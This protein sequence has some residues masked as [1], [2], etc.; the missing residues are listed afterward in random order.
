MKKIF[1]LLL[2][3]AV[4]ASVS[5][6]SFAAST[7]IDGEGSPNPATGLGNG[8]YSITVNADYIGGSGG[9]VVSVDVQWDAMTFTYQEVTL[10]TWNPGSHSYIGTVDGGWSDNKPSITVTNHSNV[11]VTAD[12]SFATGYSS[13]II[14]T[15]Y[16]KSGETY[17][18]LQSSEQTFDL[19][20]GEVGKKDEADAKTFYFGIGGNGIEHESMLGV[21]TV[22]IS[23]T[24][25]NP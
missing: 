23:K 7:S 13:G 19:A 8:E 20:A 12:F 4:F 1:A 18:A 10:G 22:S 6:T 14:G 3:I 11:D 2:C 15:F 16:S 24:I 17:T 21:I 25:S 5:V 9:D